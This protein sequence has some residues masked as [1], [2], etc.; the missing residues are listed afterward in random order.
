MYRIHGHLQDYPWGV[1]GGLR[2]WLDPGQS[3]VADPSRPEAELW[4]GAHQN[5]P[6]PIVGAHGTTLRDEVDPTRVPL[7][8]KL[9]AAAR[10]LSIQIHPPKEQAVAGFSAQQRDPSLP[11]LLS[12]SAAKIEM[13]I[14]MKPFSALAGLREPDLAADILTR[15]GGP[16]VDAAA[17][18]RAGRPKNA[19]AGLLAIPS[20]RL[21]AVDSQLP[22]AAAAAG[23]DAH[24][25]SALAAVAAN[26]PGDPGVLVAVLLEHHQLVPG[27]A[28]YL[29]AGV[30]HAYIAGTGLEV[31]TAS[32]NVLRVGLT[33]KTVAVDQALLALRPDA[34][35][36]QLRPPLIDLASGGHVRQYTPVGSPF[37]VTAICGGTIEFAE[38]VYRLVLAVT[39]QATVS[40]AGRQV[41][42]AAGEAA[43]VMDDDGPI[44]VSASADAFVA[45]PALHSVEWSA[46]SHIQ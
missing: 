7:L 36:Q 43:A 10:P 18:L 8:V 23:L 3:A 13:L 38:P 20:E 2:S 17:E 6:S 41:R 40:V 16:A 31:M 29:P 46:G 34:D 42:L 14:A 21:R 30:V 9:L 1:A 33:N 39:G 35:P 4:Y 19:I 12:D 24:G 15:V 25:V 37:D 45:S 5:G 44:T 32:D 27:E 26:Y 22:A 28:V 11:R